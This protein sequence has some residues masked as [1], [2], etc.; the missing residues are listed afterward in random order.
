MPGESARRNGR[1]G[2]RPKGARDHAARVRRI[3]AKGHGG[4]QQGRSE[5]SGLPTSGRDLREGRHDDVQIEI[6]PLTL[7]AT[8]LFH[9]L[10]GPGGRAYAEMLHRLAIEPH[11]DPGVRIKALSV[12]APFIWQ[13]LPD[14]HEA[15]GTL[16]GVTHVI[17]EYRIRGDWQ[18][19]DGSP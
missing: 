7:S 13:R 3:L 2:G 1:L 17:H 5:V 6:V 18:K 12:I 10:G 16:T 14:R 4:D 15:T 9:Q 19:P 8:D 11:D